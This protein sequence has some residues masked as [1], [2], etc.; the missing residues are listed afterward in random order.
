MKEFFCHYLIFGSVDVAPF[1]ARF[2][3]NLVDSDPLVHL[4]LGHDI[5]LA[6]GVYDAV[7]CPDVVLAHVG[8]LS[9]G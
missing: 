1:N 4:D 6:L 9:S 7:K 2:D 8:D 3:A 5:L